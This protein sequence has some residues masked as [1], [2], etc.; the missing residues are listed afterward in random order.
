M[1]LEISNETEARITGEA[2]KHG[3]SVDALL[4]R[5]MNERATITPASGSSSQ[6]EL[7]VLHM[8]PMGSLHRRDIY[9]DVR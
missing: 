1:S 9:D 7:P 6:P 8:G 2:R 3:I 5:L 4:D